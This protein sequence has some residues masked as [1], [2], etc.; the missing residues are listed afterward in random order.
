MP[1]ID[2]ENVCGVIQ[3]DILGCWKCVNKDSDFL[4]HYNAEIHTLLYK[5]DVI[6][7]NETIYICALCGI[8]IS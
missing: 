8:T 3:D 1:V 4:K 6:D 7:D 2:L 5:R